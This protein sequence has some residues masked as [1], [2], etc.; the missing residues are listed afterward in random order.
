VIE[1]R[2]ILHVDDDEDDHLLTRDALSEV[3]RT[4]YVAEWAPGFHEGLKLLTRGYDAILVDYRL[5]EHDGLSWIREARAL[6]C[7]VPMILLTGLEDEEADHA[8]LEAGAADFLLKSALS[9]ELLDRSIRYSIRQGRTLAALRD[10]EQRYVLAARG[11]NDGLWDWDLVGHQIYFSDRWKEL[12]G[13]EPGDFGAEPREWLRRVHPADLEGLRC[14]LE[15]HWRGTSSRFENEHRLR[16]RDGRYLWVLARGVCQRDERGTAL[17]FAGSLTDISTTRSTRQRLEYEASHDPLTG[18]PNRAAFVARVRSALGRARRTPDYRFAVL[19]LDL[20][21]FKTINDSLGHA[22]GDHLLVEVAHRLRGC[23][24]PGD[25]VARLGG[26]EF[27]LF[28]DHLHG[29]ADVQQIATRTLDAL[30]TPIDTGGHRLFVS[31]SIGVALSRAD[32]QAPEALLRDADIAMYRAKAAGLGRYEV[33]DARLHAETVSRLEL[34][35]DLWWALRRNELSLVY[36]PIFEVGGRDLRGFEALLRW[37]HPARGPV[38]PSDFIPLAEAAGLIHEIGR[39]VLEEACRE[40]SSWGLGT[41]GPYLSVNVS[42][43]QLA[44]PDLADT[45]AAVLAQTG[46][47]AAALR[48]ELT[49]SALMTDRAGIGGILHVLR[50]SGVRVAV[51][52]FG[53]GYSSLSSLHTL[54]V[55]ILKIDRSFVERLA[56]GGDETVRSILTLARAH[57]LSVVAEG[58]ETEDQLEALKAYGCDEAQG[59]L[60]GLPLSAR[61][62]LV[63]AAPERLPHFP[64]PPRPGRD[65]EGVR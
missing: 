5:G 39:W 11:A 46:V 64:S 9:P 33:F 34:E 8:A 51:D 20:D 60:L 36:Q 58:V 17:R 45:L 53:T 57:G 29:A 62:A 35:T 30:A 28:V 2:R 50:D 54:P 42:P 18:L 55:D 10:S 24:R 37:N 31:A 21:R 16:H 25:L 26:D 48:L 32:D 47:P 56:S 12:L 3:R 6:G 19:F 23:L 49:E 41:A 40:W 1:Q 44:R 59:Y 13:Y 63:L 15:S 52:D 4:S 65:M 27:T 22:T 61:E 38:A 43:R 7:D 14:D